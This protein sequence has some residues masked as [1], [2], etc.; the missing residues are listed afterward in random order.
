MIVYTLSSV[1]DLWLG[2]ATSGGQTS[3][4]A[5]IDLLWEDVNMDKKL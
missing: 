3:A 1:S 5:D 2:L 4:G